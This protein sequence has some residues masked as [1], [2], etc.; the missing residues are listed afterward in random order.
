MK[1][2]FPIIITIILLLTSGC[3]AQSRNLEISSVT[4]IPGKE[5]INFFTN[6][7]TGSYDISVVNF[8][9][10][11]QGS[12]TD[13][14]NYWVYARIYDKNGNFV[15]RSLPDVGFSLEPKEHRT[16]RLYFGNIDSRLNLN[17]NNINLGKIDIIFDYFN[18]E[19]K[20][21]DQFI[22]TKNY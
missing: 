12:N 16:I 22:Y 4:L 14:G 7:G 19:G 3:V 1:T 20:S 9:I 6:Q 2:N 13:L 8:V 10:T 15:A 5:V 18:D 11:N 17:F 21:T